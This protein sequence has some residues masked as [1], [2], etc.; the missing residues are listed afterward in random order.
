MLGGVPLN[1]LER[2]LAA[3]P[4]RF[5]LRF[6]QNLLSQNARFVL[7]LLAHLG[8]QRLSGLGFRHAGDL[9]EPLA[10]LGPGLLELLAHSVQLT[11]EAL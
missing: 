6:L 2:D 11:L 5:L 9:G 4:P 3:L 7:G 1:R 10:D 8:E